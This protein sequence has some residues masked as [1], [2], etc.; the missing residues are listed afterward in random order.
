MSSQ[1]DSKLHSSSIAHPLA[2]F[3]Y[4]NEVYQ[5]GLK[6]QKPSIT[7]NCLEWENLAKNRLSADSYGYVW[8][9]AGTRD[10]DDNN[11]KAFKKWGIVPSRLVRSD[12][13]DLKTTLFGETFEYPIAMAP[14]GVQRIS[15]GRGDGGSK[16]C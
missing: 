11:K 5:A 1:Q 15:T 16:G 13:P 2:P 10:T 14:V 4:E 6:G 3:K 7:F 8:G 9:S 12:F